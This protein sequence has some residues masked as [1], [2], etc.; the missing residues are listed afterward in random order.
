MSRLFARLAQGLA[1]K[2]STPALVCNFSDNYYGDR[3]CAPA[4]PAQ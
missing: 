4:R 1:P 2:A 3:V